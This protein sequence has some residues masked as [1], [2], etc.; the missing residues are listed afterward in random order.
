MLKNLWQWCSK[1]PP[2][3]CLSLTTFSLESFP[4][5]ITGRKFMVR[6]CFSSSFLHKHTHPAT[7]PPSHTHC[8]QSWHRFGCMNIFRPF[9]THIVSLQRMCY[10]FWFHFSSSRI[11]RLFKASFLK[12][13]WFFCNPFCLFLSHS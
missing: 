11:L 7:L 10:F 3:P 2:N 6:Y 13:G 8:L 9:F 12:K 4:S 1:P 5:T